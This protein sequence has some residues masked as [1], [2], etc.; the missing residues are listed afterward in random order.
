MN[1]RDPSTSLTQDLMNQAYTRWEGLD[2]DGWKKRFG[3]EGITFEMMAAVLLGNFHYQTCN[4]GLQQYWLNGY[5]HETPEEDGVQA[6]EA[7]ADIVTRSRQADPEVADMIADMAKLCGTMESPEE[8]RTGSYDEDEGQPGDPSAKLNHFDEDYFRFADE[9]IIA[10][11]DEAIRLWPKDRSPFDGSGPAHAAVLPPSKAD[12][13]PR[14][15][16]IVI[17]LADVDGNATSIIA[18][19]RQAMR[20]AGVTREEADAYAREA[21]SDDYG[22]LLRTTMGWVTTDSRTGRPRPRI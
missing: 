15:P 2:G 1:G 10:F 4:G 18:S 14:Y 20:R 11:F 7:L 13:G 22:H 5:S 8:T 21:M 16:S 6:W 9:R 3:F 17:D 12:T 19:V